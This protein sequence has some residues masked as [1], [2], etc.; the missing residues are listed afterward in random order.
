MA[1]WWDAIMGM[2]MMEIEAVD[3]IL[4]RMSRYQIQVACSCYFGCVVWCTQFPKECNALGPRQL[5]H[6]KHKHKHLPAQLGTTLSI[7]SF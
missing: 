6:N 5:Q 2:T 4:D 3:L 7:C 1:M